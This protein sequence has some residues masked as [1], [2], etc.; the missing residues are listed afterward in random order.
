M[1]YSAMGDSHMRYS[2]YQIV[3]KTGGPQLYK[4]IGEDINVKKWHF[5]W[6]NYCH[7]LKERLVEYIMERDQEASSAEGSEPSRHLLLF[8]GGHW[9]I[10]VNTIQVCSSQDRGKEGER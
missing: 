1:F 2:F 5:K 7:V 10:R 6:A 9:D 8:E 3:R 4:K